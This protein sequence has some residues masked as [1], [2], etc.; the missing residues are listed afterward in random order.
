M[1][2]HLKGLLKMLQKE[3]KSKASQLEKIGFAIGA[4]SSLLGG[5]VKDFQKGAKKGRRKM[6]AAARKRISEA[7][8]RRWAAKA[9]AA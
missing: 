2:T 6:S 7:M 3:Q 9:K 1:E 8:K 4:I 5:S